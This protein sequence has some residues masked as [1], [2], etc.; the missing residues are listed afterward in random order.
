M[1]IISSAFLQYYLF[2][3][4]TIDADIELMKYFDAWEDSHDAM[5]AS[6]N[7]SKALHCVHYV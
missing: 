1:S 6:Y 3:A 4:I 7:L 2:S 5:G